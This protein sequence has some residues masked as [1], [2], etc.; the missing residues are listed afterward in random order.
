MVQIT[1]INSASVDATDL[2]DLIFGNGVSIQSASYT[3]DGRSAGIF[4][5]GNAQAPGVTPSDTGVIL[6]TGR[7]T[8]FDTDGTDPNDVPNTTTNTSGPNNNAQ[9]NALAGASTFD[10]AWLDVD[11]IPTGDTLSMQ[12]VFASEEYPEYTN[13]IFNDAVGVWINGQPA[14]LSVGDGSTSVGNLNQVDNINLY[15][16]NTG[17]AFQTE[18]DGFTVTLTLTMTVIPNVVNSIRIGIADVGDS[19][20]DSNLLI[21]ANSLQTELIANDDVVRLDAN[22]SKTFDVLGNDQ[23]PTGATL[24]I[25]H[26]NGIA[27]ADGTPVAG[28]T[29][30]D[31]TN[32]QSIVLNTN[33]TITIVSDAEEEIAPFSYT[34]SDGTNT[35]TAFVTVN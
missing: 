30:F 7:A 25:T 27:I 2:A 11:F 29:Q 20:Y 34:I 28:G 5:Q 21:A 32:G 31:L 3:G 16:D 9:F 35:D 14:T 8:G 12:F 19:S 13:S 4:T 18:M 23:G 15:N 22:S 10:A 26:I 24:T 33:G 1:T 6:S 17:D